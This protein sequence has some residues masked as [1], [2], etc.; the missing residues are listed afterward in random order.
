M[1]VPPPDGGFDSFAPAT[2]AQQEEARQTLRRVFDVLAGILELAH[3]WTG[4]VALE[5]GV[6]YAGVARP[7]CDIRIAAHVWNHPVFR[8][9]TLLH[10][11]L[12]KFSPPFTR[13][14]YEQFEGWEEGV[15]EQ[16]QR[17][18]RREA[19]DK[20]GVAA[21]VPEDA[22]AGAEAG[23]RYNVYI[24]AL[25]SLRML[26]CEEEPEGFYRRLLETPLPL[27]FDRLMRAADALAEPE[28]TTFRRATLIAHAR[29]SRS[30][31]GA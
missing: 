7:E 28:R 4:E 9:R 20:I 16:L 11:A 27:R 17:L 2:E 13:R 22:L 1:S 15:V 6:F 5:S 8:W 31:H 23:H 26:W 3:S 25:E 12:H 18:L 30:S 19:L 21:G 24:A 29:L 10:E 14:E